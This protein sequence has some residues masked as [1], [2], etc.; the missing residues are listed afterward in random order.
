MSATAAPILQHVL[1]DDISPSKDNPRRIDDKHPSLPGLAESIK[2]Q[3]VLQPIIV[4]EDPAGWTIVAGERRW[5][6]AR[7][8]GLERMPVIVRVM[9]EQE[10][11]EAMNVENLQREDLHWT[12]ETRGVEN[13]MKRGY[14]VARIAHA[15]GRTEQWVRLRA[16]LAE[17]SP[18]WRKAVENPRSDFHGWPMAMLE[19]IARLPIEVQEGM[20]A[21]GRDQDWQLRR[22]GS[23]A[24]LAKHLDREYLRSLKAAVWDVNDATLVPKAG[25]CSA[26]P[27][28]SSCQQQLFG[29]VKDDR[30]L[31]A[32]CWREKRDAGVIAK[33]KALQKE[34]PKA[35]L[36]QGEGGVS[37]DDIP[38]PFRKAKLVATWEYEKVA[39]SAPGAVPVIHVAGDKAGKVVFMKKNGSGGSGAAA[40]SGKPKTIPPKERLEVFLK[41][42][43]R[44]VVGAVIAALGGDPD[45]SPY[46]VRYQEPQAVAAGVHAPSHGA[47]I[48]L[49]LTLGIDGDE[50]E[51]WAPYPGLLKASGELQEDHLWFA[52]R[53]S[54]LKKLAWDRQNA[55]LDGARYMA[56]A[57]G[58]DWGAIV[59]KAQDDHPLPRTLAEI[60]NEDGSPKK[61]L[62]A[63]AKPAKKTK[64]AKS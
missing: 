2:A 57:C 9:T 5:R 60:F 63:K 52:V 48:A 26:C 14:D 39:A 20:L 49:A 55:E 44:D 62:T 29:E 18:A 4:R 17:I 10:A 27:K 47:L 21:E 22:C 45:M 64:A 33:V 56:V 15:L 51:D 58:I 61:G 3:G 43:H 8:A 1:I 54:V 28:R 41:R 11:F 6:A 32:A 42:R 36:T 37:G 16:K 50:M 40:A 46:Q 13:M 19:Q 38:A 25:A 30:C 24:D 12:E 7:L 31:D 23:A 34:H 35:L 53:C 59:S